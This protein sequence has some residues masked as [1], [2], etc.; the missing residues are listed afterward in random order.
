MRRIKTDKY[1]FLNGA[2]GWRL[3]V[4]TA[5]RVLGGD[6]SLDDV[7]GYGPVYYWVNNNGCCST[8]WKGDVLSLE[9]EV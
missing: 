7:Q 6:V 2:M 8:D 3:G 1:T 5:E 4:I 9:L